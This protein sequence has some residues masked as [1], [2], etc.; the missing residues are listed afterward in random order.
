MNITFKAHRADVKSLVHLHRSERNEFKARLA[1][2]G[3]T[4]GLDPISIP[5]SCLDYLRLLLRVLG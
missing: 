2:P 5:V 4:M 1:S 3:W